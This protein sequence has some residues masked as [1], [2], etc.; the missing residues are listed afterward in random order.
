MPQ[1]AQS[2]TAPHLTCS[3]CRGIP[4]RCRSFDKGGET[5]ENT[6]PPAVNRLEVV[7]APFY[8]QEFTHSNRCL[9]R[10]P[11]CGTFYE[12]DFEY[13]YL[14]GGSEDDLTIT[15]LDWRTALSKPTGSRMR[16]PRPGPAS[17][18]RRHRVYG[19]SCTPPT[20]KPFARPPAGSS[21]RSRTATT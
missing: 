15:R 17:P 9:L 10:C 19:L 14:A 8:Q 13:E 6:I 21:W 1:S 7:G 12:W 2:P 16:W 20:R 3:I 5:V 18:P 4:D 11:E